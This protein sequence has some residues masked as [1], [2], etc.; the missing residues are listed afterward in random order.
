MESLD[1]WEQKSES[2]TLLFFKEQQERFA[3]GRSFVKSDET[4][5]LTVSLT[6]AL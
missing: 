1:F 4:D 3:H 2:L 5:L 6:V